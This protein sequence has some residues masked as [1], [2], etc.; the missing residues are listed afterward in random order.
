MILKPRRAVFLDRDGTI[1]QEVGHVRSPDQVQ[2]IPGAAQAMVRLRRAGLALVVVS[3][4]S[5]L[6]RG[7]LN[8]ADL[9]A[10]QAELKRQLALAGAFWDEFF[11]CPH[12]P[13]G[14]VEGLG[15]VCDCRK[16]EPG[17][18]RRAAD[19][20]ALSL[21]G[22]FMVG[23]SR[24]DVAC[25]NALGLTSILVESGHAL[26]PAASPAEEPA[27]VAPDLAAAAD[28]ILARLAG[29]GGAL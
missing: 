16:P 6:A 28:W 15:M 21:E 13:E 19:Q 5:G 20:M 12:H 29:E 24:R 7:V 17:L 27:L 11:F 3:N 18:L 4:Q 14:V 1:N 2:L 25:G 22:S 8:Q 26:V 9:A 10:V 23:D